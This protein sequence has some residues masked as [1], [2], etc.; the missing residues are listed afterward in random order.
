[1]FENS[2]RMSHYPAVSTN[3]RY[4]CSFCISNKTR[5]LDRFLTI[6]FFKIGANVKEVI[7]FWYNAVA[8]N[9]PLLILCLFL[10]CMKVTRTT[11]ILKSVRW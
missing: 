7:F 6:L 1:M 10:F 9:V 11:T 8:F 4:L 5:L 3:L 2:L